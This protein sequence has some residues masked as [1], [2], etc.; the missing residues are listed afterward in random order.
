MG[1]RRV[2]APP[3]E[4]SLGVLAVYSDV[5]QPERELARASSHA[6]ER[7]RVALDL[8]PALVKVLERAGK[9]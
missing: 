2:R 9:A 7:R 6:L 4:L 1:E 8:G 5:E 3:K